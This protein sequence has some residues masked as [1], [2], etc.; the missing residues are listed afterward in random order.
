MRLFV[1]FT[2]VLFVLLSLVQGLSFGDTQTAT[3]DDPEV[4]RATTYALSQAYDQKDR[5]AKNAY[6]THVASF[7]IVHATKQLVN[8]FKYELT[9]EITAPDGYCTTKQFGVWE[10]AHPDGSFL[11]ENILLQ[12]PC[13]TP[14]V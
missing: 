2:L 1:L 14:I 12:T 6:N 13:G 10:R 9:V 8:G 3:V 7:K 11:I 4:I 5:S